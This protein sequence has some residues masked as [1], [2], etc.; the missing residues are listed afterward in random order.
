MALLMAILIPTMTGAR[1]QAR[2]VACRSSLSQWG[3][4]FMMYSIDDGGYF[5]SGSGK[6]WKEFLQAYYVEP[7]L[8]CCPAPI[9]VTPEVSCLAK[10]TTH[11]GGQLVRGYEIGLSKRQPN[12]VGWKVF[13]LGCFRQHPRVFCRRQKRGR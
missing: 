6:L 4:I 12:T 8:R 7:D 9:E 5:P 3:K 10:D 1:K 11:V 13:G 2:A